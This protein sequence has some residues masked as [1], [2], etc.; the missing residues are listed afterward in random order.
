MDVMDVHNRIN[1]LCEER[2]YTPYELAKRS[3]I[4]QSCLYNMFYRGTM[5][6]IETLDRI[7]EGLDIDLS[8]FFLVWSKPRVGG[9]ISEID[10]DLLTVSHSLTEFNQKQLLAY[11]RGMMEAQK[12]A[13]AKIFDYR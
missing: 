8:E 12:N 13:G 6:R 5:P 1:A 11:A 3:G 4:A 10:A 7:C 9:Y 2:G